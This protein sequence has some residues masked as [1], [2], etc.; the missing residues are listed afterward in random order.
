MNV[1][2][3]HHYL[4]VFFLKGFVNDEGAFS[5]FDCKKRQLKKG[6]YFPSSHFFEFGRNTTNF[7]GT[8]SDFTE[9]GYGTKDNRFAKLFHKIQQCPGIPEL[10][11]MEMF[12]LQEFISNTF[13]RIPK[14]DALFKEQLQTNPLFKNGY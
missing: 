8:V 13:W 4:P 9:K 5:V 1:T 7:E 3:K 6:R 2:R 10:D 11:E 12:A 14:N